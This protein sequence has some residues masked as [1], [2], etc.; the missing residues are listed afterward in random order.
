MFAL[1]QDS[2]GHTDDV[3]GYR[4]RC[5]KS[6]HPGRPDFVDDDYGDLTGGRADVMS[7]ALNGERPVLV[8][9]IPADED[10]RP[11]MNVCHSPS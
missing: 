6:D 2:L 1:H 7:A 3:A 4:A 5:S 9:S 10:C 8:E 11:P